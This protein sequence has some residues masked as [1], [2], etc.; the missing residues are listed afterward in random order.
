MRN[1][2]SQLIKINKLINKIRRAWWGEKRS[3]SGGE[4]EG[5]RDGRI[6]AE[7]SGKVTRKPGLNLVRRW[8]V[9]ADGSA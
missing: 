4:G 3:D 9:A 6:P 7:A 5:R 8:L 2:E 1:Y